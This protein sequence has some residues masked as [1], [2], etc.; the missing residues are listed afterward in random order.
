MGQGFDV[1]GIVDILNCEDDGFVIDVVIGYSKGIVGFFWIFGYM[2]IGYDVLLF[3]KVKV[4]IEVIF[5]CMYYI[6]VQFWILIQYVIGCG[7]FKKYF[8]I[9]CVVFGWMIDVDGQNG[10]MMFDQNFG[11]VYYLFFFLF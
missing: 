5:D 1:E 8:Y 10:I 2:F 7:D 6:Y 11:F 9:D 3:C 4:G